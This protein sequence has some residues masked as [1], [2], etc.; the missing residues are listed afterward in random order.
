MIET[1]TAEMPLADFYE[2][3]YRPRKLRGGQASTLH[4]NRVTLRQFAE[5]LGRTPTVGDLT[6]KH[7][8]GFAWSRVDAG[9]SRYTACLQ[10][11]TLL[12]WWRFACRQGVLPVWPDV[13]LPKPIV[14]VPVAWS[15]EQLQ[16]LHEA[17]DREPGDF[18]GVP[19]RLWL[20][21]LHGVLWDTGERINAVINL[22]WDDVDLSIG[23]VTFRGEHRK[24]HKKD[25]ANKLHAD[26]VE[27]LRAILTPKRRLVFPVWS[28]NSLWKWYGSFL[29]RAGLPH[30]RNHKFHCWRRSVASYAEAAGLNATELLDHS[31]R[32]VTQAY[33][34]PKITTQKHACD[35]LFRPA[36][37]ERV[38]PDGTQTRGTFGHQISVKINGELHEMGPSE[39]ALFRILCEHPEGVESRLLNAMLAQAGRSATNKN[40]NS[41]TAKLRARLRAIYHLPETWDPILVERTGKVIPMKGRPPL[42]ETQTRLNLPG[43]GGD[44]AAV[45]EKFADLPADVI[46][47]LR[48]LLP[49]LTEREHEVLRFSAQGVFCPE[50]AKMLKLGK[51]TVSRALKRALAKLGLTNHRGLSPLFRG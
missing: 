41:I 2:N 44:P 50:I 11:R 3:V 12:A 20:H 45:V 48:P 5:W 33:L 51:M 37:E 31:Q 42:P 36:D 4:T 18:Y 22:A 30:D 19:R 47:R 49:L 40:R 29:Q 16:T 35:T 14:R 15:R 34:D 7:V 32:S 21:A 26:T 46:D 13:E 38:D 6:E 28:G 25:R 27:K 1:I 23:W 39:A 8:A 24:F 17:A 10:G 9:K 43:E